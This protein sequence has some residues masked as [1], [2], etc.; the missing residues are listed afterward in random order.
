[1]M[2]EQDKAMAQAAVVQARY[3]DELLTYPNVQGTAIGLSK[4]HGEYTETIALVV[5]VSHK[6]PREELAPDEIIPRELE[7]VPVEVQEIGFIAAQ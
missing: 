3:N 2:S 1:M 5:L 7:G 4:V 6:V